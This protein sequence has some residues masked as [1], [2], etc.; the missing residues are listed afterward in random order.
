MGDKKFGRPFWLLVL[1]VFGGHLLTRLVNASGAHHVLSSF[2]GYLYGA[3]LLALIACWM[4]P[5]DFG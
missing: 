5:E 4:Y 2:V 3:L 1:I